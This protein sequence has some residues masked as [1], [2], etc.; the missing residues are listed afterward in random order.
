MEVMA[1]FPTILI[2][3]YEKDSLMEDKAAREET[4][5]L[6]PINLFSI[7]L[8]SEE[9]T[10]MEIMEETEVRMAKMAKMEVKQ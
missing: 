7:Y 2:K 3:E 9:E 5:A 4:F 8:I 10:L 6:K 1:A